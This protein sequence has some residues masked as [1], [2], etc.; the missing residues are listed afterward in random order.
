M[1][2]N[3]NMG[4]TVILLMNIIYESEEGDGDRQHIA[5]AEKEYSQNVR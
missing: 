5:H 4:N 2:E 3:M 1:R